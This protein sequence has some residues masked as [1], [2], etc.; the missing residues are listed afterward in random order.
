[1]VEARDSCNTNGSLAV[2]LGVHIFG[3][4]YIL[5]HELLEEGEGD[6]SESDVQPVGARR[7]RSQWPPSRSAVKFCARVASVGEDGRRSAVAA[8]CSGDG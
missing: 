8:Q 4:H 6:A 3:N 7:R 1:L 2:D 5:V